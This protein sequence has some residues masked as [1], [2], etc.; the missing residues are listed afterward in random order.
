MNVLPFLLVVPPWSQ[1]ICYYND[2]QAQEINMLDKKQQQVFFFFLVD[3]RPK[4]V[5]VCVHAWY[6]QFGYVIACNWALLLSPV[7]RWGSRQ[8]WVVGRHGY[9]NTQHWRLIH[10]ALLFSP[11]YS[12]P[13]YFPLTTQQQLWQRESNPFSLFL[14][15]ISPTASIEFSAFIFPFFPGDL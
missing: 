11:R 12:T 3:F 8:I 13:F 7:F 6:F 4:H 9:V 2:Q 5:A 14:L 10:N 15:A 1:N